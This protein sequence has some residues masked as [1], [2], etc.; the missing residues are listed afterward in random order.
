MFL[1][2]ELILLSPL[3]IYT[4]IRVLRLFSRNVARILFTAGFVVLL[5]GF[6]VA[7]TLSHRG[8]GGLTKG[9]MIAGYD[10][11]PLLLYLVLIVILSD[12]AIGAAAGCP[13]HAFWR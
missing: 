6:P 5:A 8:A 10:A 2:N 7:E 9:V 11:L 1:L 12:L 4:H 13:S 3:A